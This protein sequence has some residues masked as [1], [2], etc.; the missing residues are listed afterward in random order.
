MSDQRT[1]VGEHQE[2]EWEGG[3]DVPQNG[4]RKPNIVLIVADDL[5]WN[6]LTVNGG[7]VAGGTVPT[8]N[9]DSIAD[10]GVSFTNGYAGQGT[11]APSRAMMMS[12]RYGSRFGF[13][14]TPTPAGMSTALG[15]MAGGSE[16]RSIPNENARSVPYER[17]G[18]PA[19]E[20]TIAELLKDQGYYTAHIG[21]WHL[22]RENGSAPQDQGFDQS[23]LMHSGL[24]AEEDDPDVVNSRLSY[25][26]IDRFL[27]AGMKYAA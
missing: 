24:Y 19:S 26:P 7:G 5:G 10:A 18:L 1:P 15:L 23:L 3:P 4:E 17:M 11:C 8:P 25:D 6:D 9:I 16:P 13:E 12:G 22:G 27:W 20:I 14:F 2:V 21:K